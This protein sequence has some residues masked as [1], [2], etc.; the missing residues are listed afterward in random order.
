MNGTCQESS[1]PLG[2]AKAV[3]HLQGSNQM[4]DGLLGVSTSASVLRGCR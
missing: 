3:G 4:D 2:I 1:P